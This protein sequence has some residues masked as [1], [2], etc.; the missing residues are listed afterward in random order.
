MLLVM[1]YDR[2]SLI[3]RKRARNTKIEQ[4]IKILHTTLGLITT[5]IMNTIR[6]YI[7]KALIFWR[8]RD[9][10][11]ENQVI[12]I[13]KPEVSKLESMNTYSYLY[14]E[15]CEHIAITKYYQQSCRIQS[16]DSLYVSNNNIFIHP[17]TSY[18]L[19]RFSSLNLKRITIIC[20][21]C[22]SLLY[23]TKHCET[24]RY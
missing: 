10:I 21:I 24:P 9:N 8:H 4:W 11:R 3:D 14:Y 23:S 1:T 16:T 19:L 5:K 6:R 18:I 12:R 20:I 22:V 15:F 13:E 2:E 17:K 7:N